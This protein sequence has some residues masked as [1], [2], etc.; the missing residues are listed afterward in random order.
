MAANLAALDVM[1]S[2][3]QMKRIDALDRPDG[4]IGPDPAQFG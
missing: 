4:R 3:E 2:D 1:L